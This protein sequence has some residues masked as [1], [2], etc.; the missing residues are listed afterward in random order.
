[1]TTFRGIAGRLVV[2][3][4]VDVY[5]A[6]GVFT[7]LEQ[8]QPEPVPIKENDPLR[9]IL[10]P[11][12]SRSVP[13]DDL[14]DYEKILVERLVMGEGS[15]SAT[16]L[17]LPMVYGPGDNGH[18]LAP[19]LRRMVDGRPAILVNERMARWRCPRGYVEDVAAAALTVQ[20][21][22]AAGKVYNVAEPGAFAEAEWIAKIA[23]VFGW[24]GR[25]IAVPE[26]KM[27]VGFNTRQDLVVDATRIRTELHFQEV[28]AAD[29]TLRATIR[30]EQ[31]HLAEQPVDYQA[32]DALLAELSR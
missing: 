18:R 31:H 17:R 16:V 24:D 6:Y 32:E 3:S 4:S 7:G 5:R 19:Y 25:V 23:A 9:K 21:P 2:I 13:G 29:D 15:F 28:A 12:R 22:A 14:Y 30:W 8:G 1:V 27:P 26:A 11:Y 20:N 10:Y